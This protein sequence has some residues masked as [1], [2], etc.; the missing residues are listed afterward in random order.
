[1]CHGELLVDIVRVATPTP[2]L[3]KVLNDEDDTIPKETVEVKATIWRHANNVKIARM[4]MF[5]F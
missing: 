3:R 2:F 5:T 1:M 4:M